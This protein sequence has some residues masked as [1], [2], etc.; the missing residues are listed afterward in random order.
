MGSDIKTYGDL[1]A[2][3]RA[4]ELVTR[5]YCES[6]SLPVDER[7]GLVAQM[8]RSTVAMASNIAEGW[9]RGDTDDFTRFLRIARG[10]LFE[11]STQVEICVRLN[12]E[13]N[14][15]NVLAAIDEVGRVLHGLIRSREDR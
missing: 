10:S 8:R 14:W 7:F 12:Y 13:G 3:Q 9:G 6:K 2:W 11:L 5:V 4:L 15:I 1:V